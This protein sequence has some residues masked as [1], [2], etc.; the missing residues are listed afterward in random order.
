MNAPYIFVLDWDGTI[1][2]KVEFQSYAYNVRSVL[3][4]H[5]FR[6]NEPKVTVPKAFTHKSKLIRPGF[7]T[8]VK[9]LTR[10]FD[11]NVFFFVYTA[12]EKTWAHQE[13]QWFEK[14][15]GI[16]FQRPI[17]TRDDCI[18][19][20]S[21][22]YK[23]SIAK[24]FPR[25]CRV[26]GNRTKRVLTKSEKEYILDATLMVI[27]N[28]AVYLDNTNRLLVCPHYNYAVF[29]NLYDMF[30]SASKSHP[31]IQRL[32]LSLINAGVMCPLP[33]HDDDMFRIYNMYTWITLKCKNVIDMNEDY[34]SDDFWKRLR[35]L[36]VKNDIRVFSDDTIVKLQNILWKNK[37]E[38]L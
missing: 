34:V 16:K 10:H 15:H 21:S 8:F 6:A 27:D 4:K 31:E 3:K 9:T 17:F 26:V 28:N 22:S 23:K 7:A 37:N 38:S 13:I 20:E 29:E 32:M 11:G 18:I 12:S 35:R 14:A 2:G 19:D 24:I 33:Q 1:A 36:I 5:G 30:P 25:I